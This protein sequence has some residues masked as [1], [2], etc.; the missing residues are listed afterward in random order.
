MPN[1]N[2]SRSDDASRA[3]ELRP[4]DATSIIAMARHIAANEELYS[5]ADRQASRRKHPAFRIAHDTAFSAMCDSQFA[6][7]RL[8]PEGDDRDLMLLVGAA[9]MLAD[10][11]PDIIPESDK[12]GTKLCE[13]IKAALV[14][15]SATLA[16]EWP[17]GPD[18]IAEIYP[19]VA[20]CI[21]QDVLI[22]DALR[23]DA[24]GI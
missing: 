18:A 20:R 17:A 12:H 5:A 10:Q 8:F 16:K 24:G 1:G 14:T 4:D 19:E 3:A 15:I 7:L 9:S 11:L 22:T 21:R 13:G 23:A 2:Q 6:L